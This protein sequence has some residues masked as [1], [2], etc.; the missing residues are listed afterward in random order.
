MSPQPLKMIRVHISAVPIPGLD[1]AT[2]ADLKGRAA[3]LIERIEVRI[4]AH[5]TTVR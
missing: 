3:Q 4:S 5:R 2:F 1:P